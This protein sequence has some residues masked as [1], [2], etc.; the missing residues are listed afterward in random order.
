MNN[1]NKIDMAALM[2]ILS[3]MDKSELEARIMQ[4]NKI[5]QSKD[6]NEVLKEINKKMNKQD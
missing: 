5:L 3:K 1:N 4:A 2:Q 6:K